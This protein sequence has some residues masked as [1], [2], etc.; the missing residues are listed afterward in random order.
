MSGEAAEKEHEPSAR[1]LE[2]AREKGDI[3]RSPDV[4]TAAAYAGL[5]LAAFG[6]GAPA[7]LAAGTAAE[8]LLDQ[9]DG[10]SR[11][12][13]D[14]AS[15]PAGGILLRFAG[16]IAP[17]LVL[18]G[19]AALA[20]LVAQRGILFTGANL[21]PRL[22]RLSPIAGARHKFGPDGLFEFAKGLA[23]MVLICLAL[24]WFLSARAGAVM[25]TLYL[26]PA[27]TA[28]LLSRLIAEFLGIV[29]LVAGAMAAADLLWQRHRHAVRNRMSRQEVTDEHREQEGDP[30]AKAQR[31]QRGMDIA[32][33]RMLLDVPRASVVIVNPTHYAVALAWDRAGSRAPVCVAKG[34]DEVAAR[35]REAAAKAG[36][37]VRSDPPTARALHATVEI[38]QEIRPDAYRAVAAAIRFAEAMRRRAR[39]R[40]R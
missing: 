17:F 31:R 28:A 15:A 10:L 27:M 14:G 16:A 34:V 18:P 33:N 7:L 2:Q 39:E 22:S 12:L 32:T 37:P 21:A 13:F 26:E 6:L 3:A 35:I 9:A 11:L 4:A 24:G 36:V 23:K 29:V 25:A 38:G 5:A 20:A 8:V 1:R 30:H 19:L 40:R